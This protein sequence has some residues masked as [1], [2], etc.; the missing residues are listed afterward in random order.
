[1]TGIDIINASDT[2]LGTL[3]H[4]TIDSGRP[5]GLAL[6]NDGKTL[7]VADPGL[8][9]VR[10]Y[11]IANT[12]APVWVKNIA[13]PTTAT[14]LYKLALNS[15]GTI[16]YVTNNALSGT[17]YSV[18]L[19]Q[20]NP[21]PK[22]EYTGLYYPS[23]ILY[24]KW[25]TPVAYNGDSSVSELL[26]VQVDE[27]EVNNV[28]GNNNDIIVMK[29]TSGTSAA[30]INAISLYKQLKATDFGSALHGNAAQN[31]LNNM[32]FSANRKYIYISHYLPLTGKMAY[33]A[34]PTLSST[35]TWDTTKLKISIA[36]SGTYGAQKDQII[37]ISDGSGLLIACSQADQ[38]KLFESPATPIG[39]ID[40]F[41]ADAPTGLQV[42]PVSYHAALATWDTTDF[43]QGYQFIYYKQKT[44]GTQKLI[45]TPGLLIDI[46]S[47]EASTTYEAIV[48]GYFTHP[49]SG[50]T[51]YTN[52]NYPAVPFTTFANNSNTITKVGVKA[53]VRGLYD[54]DSGIQKSAR[55]VL[56]ARSNL[57]TVV[58][59]SA[60]TL[61]DT[62]GAGAV[63]FSNLP[64]GSYYLVVKQAI[65]S[66]PVGANHLPMASASTVTLS[67][68]STSNNYDFTTQ[69][70]HRQSIDPFLLINGK[71]YMIPGDYNADGAVDISDFEDCWKKANGSDHTQAGFNPAYD[72]DGNG[73]IEISELEHWKLGNGSGPNL[74]K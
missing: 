70:I 1:M 9:I 67:S 18:D 32:V 31:I 40:Q 38:V 8:Q 44:T 35:A 3:S 29:L 62:N 28:L 58:A 45:D 65:A 42:V 74:P 54:P 55:I 30:K 52:Y 19:T 39:T 48:R 50:V 57:S 53:L 43:V 24:R 4:F 41:N 12:N 56:E 59:T 16:L 21:T 11:N 6:S 36:E 71:Q 61:L 23:N 17:L 47:L 14:S 25:N 2:S 46:N 5:A 34:Y 72:S 64:N 37:P 51:Y 22:A 68:A 27:N 13:F 69:S 10:V 33:Y 7:Y 63:E 15:T 73:A 20:A 66:I 26:F 60:A 49:I